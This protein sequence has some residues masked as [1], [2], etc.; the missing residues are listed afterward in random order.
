MKI[1]QDPLH[2]NNFFSKNIRVTCEKTYYYIADDDLCAEI[3]KGLT[4][5]GS[6]FSW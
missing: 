3:A 2:I 6:G 5:C 1:L 4:Y